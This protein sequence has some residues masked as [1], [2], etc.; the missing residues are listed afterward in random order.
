MDMYDYSGIEAS[1]KRIADSLEILA[2]C[3]QHEHSKVTKDTNHFF[4]VKNEEPKTPTD[5]DGWE[6]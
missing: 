3:V 1:L 2:S 4:E 6:L 5:K